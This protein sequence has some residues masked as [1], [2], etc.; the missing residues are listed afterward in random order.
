MQT[1]DVVL[2]RAS[3]VNDNFINKV[4]NDDLPTP[5]DSY[6]LSDTNLKPKDALEIFISQLESRILDLTARK[7][8][9][10]DLSF[11]TIGSS[12]HEGNAAIACA[13]SY[14]DMA[15]LHY[16]SGAFML[17]RARM[18]FGTSKMED[19]L[20][21]IVAAK[22]CPISQ[23]R[24]KVFGSQALNVP[25]QTSTIASH[26][27][28]S[29]GAAFALNI[30]KA[31]KIKSRIV[32]DSVVICSFGDAS[33]NHSTAQGA[34]NSSRWIFDH[35]IPLPII[36]ICE[37]NGIGISV[38]TKSNWI[39]DSVRAMPGIEYIECDGL[40]F[41]DV[42]EK[43]ILARKKALIKKQPVFLHMKTVRLLGHAGSDIEFH[44]KTKAEIENTEKNDPLL[45]SAKIIIENNILSNNEIIDRYTN[46]LDKVYQQGKE[47][48]VEPKLNS[49]TE[50]MASIIPPKKNHE[51]P[52][53]PKS[54]NTG[55]YNMAQAINLA[56]KDLM[57]QY[58][59]IV[60][61]GED[62]GKKGG[63]YRVTQNLQQEFGK[64]RVFDS[65]LDEQTILGTAI[66]MSLNGLLPIPEIQFLAY[67]HNAADQIRG[68]AATQSFFSNG[69]YSN[70]MVI[71]IPGLA[72]QKGFGGHFH[73]DNAIGFL[74]EIPG[75]II[76][77]PSNAD[78]AA[79]L[80]RKCVALAYQEQRVVVF[81]EPIALYYIKDLYPY[82]AC[83]HVANFGEFEIFG[84]SSVENII[85]S[86]GNGTK[87]AIEAA[88]LIEQKNS[89]K[90]AVLDLQW[91]QPLNISAISKFIKDKARVLI[92]DETRKTCSISDSL[93]A[94]L[95]EELQLFK[96]K[97]KL[98]RLTADDCFIPL[99]HSWQYVL[100][101]VENIIKD[102]M[103]ML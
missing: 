57:Y 44:Y 12:G 15:F 40:N 80:L 68:E 103:S 95:F 1:Q 101:S 94:G 9:K 51:I 25:P 26:L 49:K 43:T 35:N 30:A 47:L 99:G 75:I 46:L 7:L 87:L 17:Q 14:D 102:F 58:E 74:R 67:V 32:D 59:N 10:D 64:R 100:P 77:C 2:D 84:D 37:D 76:A 50:V 61:F 3:I 91:L 21:A 22:A 70:P 33:F 39:R 90:L 56:L 98:K 62:V 8:K 48:A 85:L 97:P 83:S 24:H 93:I 79:K 29:V 96:N 38:P 42:F 36:F 89:I 16:R 6:L 41:V 55:S 86:F 72:Y 73:N 60:V 19:H 52:V 66:G 81:I 23:G 18:A 34:I 20:L 71:R 28:K 13:T 88:K 5:R 69:Q 54:K 11:Y 92:V 27:P 78:N 45:Y 53:P 65:M 63:V 31:L 82:P 4:S